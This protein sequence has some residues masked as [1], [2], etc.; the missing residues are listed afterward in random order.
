M[1]VS[2]ELTLPP[3]LTGAAKESARGD[4]DIAVVHESD[5]HSVIETRKKAVL[6]IFFELSVDFCRMDIHAGKEL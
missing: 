5:N 2:L 4:R 3:W 6:F 1:P